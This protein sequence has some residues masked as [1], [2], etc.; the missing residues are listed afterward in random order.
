[1][2]RFSSALFFVGKGLGA[3]RGTLVL[4]KVTHF[5]SAL[6]IE[7]LGPSLAC[8]QVSAGVVVVLQWCCSGVAVVLQW[9]CCGVAVVLQWCCIGDAVVLQWC[10]GGVAVVLQC[11]SGVAVV[12]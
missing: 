9:C 3:K 1:V 7:G 8:S 2:T 12:L 5:A 10:C 4:E 6:S 11:C